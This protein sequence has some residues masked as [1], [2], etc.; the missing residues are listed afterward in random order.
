[1]PLQTERKQRVKQKVGIALIAALF[2][3]L[4]SGILATRGFSPAEGWYSYYAYRINEQGAV[5]Y[6]D[7]ELLFPPLYTYV[8]AFFTRL[9]GSDILPL[10]VL[11]VVIFS[12]T[13]AVAALLF[14]KLTDS[15]LFGLLG[16]LLAVS[17]L[18]SEVV[19]VFYDY[20]RFMDL[21]VYLSLYFFLRFFKKCDD[22]TPGRA[23]DA[24][25]F[26]GALFAVLASMYKQ[27][28]GLL[29]LLYVLLM[30]AFFLVLQ[31]E[32]KVFAWTLATAF[33]V[34]VTLYGA[35][36]LLL[37]RKGALSSYLYYNF[38]ASVSAKGGNLASLLFGWIGRD[39]LPLMA[40]ILGAAALLAC[41]WWVCG[42]ARRHPDDGKGLSRRAWVLM[43]AAAFLIVTG[44]ILLVGFCY[45]QV[46]YFFFHVPLL[47]TVLVFAV[48]LFVIMAVAQLRGRDVKPVRK[49]H[50]YRTLFMAGAVAVLGLAVCTSGGVSESQ[51]ALGY[52][53]MAAVAYP[54]FTFRKKE[55]ASLV[56]AALMLLYTGISWSRKYAEMYSWWGLK[57][58]TVAAQNTP[59]KAPLLE[60]IQT[61]ASYAA[62]YNAV[63]EVA[64]ASTAAE[65]TMFAFP[66]MP[67]LYL[68]AERP[69]AT[70]TAIQWFDVT[71]DSAVVAD[72]DVLRAAPPKM[73]VLSTVP[74]YAVE[75]HERAFREG[76]RSGLGQMREFLADFVVEE[77]YVTA[78]VYPLCE[79]YT[80]TIWLLPS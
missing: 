24:N 60:G 74:D 75:A 52:S 18:Q 33:G 59:L 15:P 63:Y 39:Y 67:V 64:Q 40:G 44:G 32:K 65:D 79:G 71:T 34:A 27:S 70:N 56:L 3:A 66:H 37:A 45:A 8:I 6:V 29:F 23:F 57:I 12:M 1:M 13:G 76:T 36:F 38:N 16:G 48:A 35:M 10:R 7:F 17:V 51:L 21:H 69:C 46:Q 22:G 61:D 43:L 41:A 77:G 53:L 73:L 14:E 4:L 58:T 31:K 20:I 72:I 28:S 42:Y 55:V 68:V 19:Q 50:T 49:T 9:F 11:G 30:L 5:P 2:C 25:V 62:L 54:L 80:V 26:F 47:M 78:G